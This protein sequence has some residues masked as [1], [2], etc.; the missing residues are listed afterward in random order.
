MGTI[1]PH[2]YNNNYAIYRRKEEEI[3]QQ[4]ITS[5][6]TLPPLPTIQNDYNN[7]IPPINKIDLAEDNEDETFDLDFTDTF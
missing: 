6:V 2:N 5:S 1:D 4:Q 7:N 3:K